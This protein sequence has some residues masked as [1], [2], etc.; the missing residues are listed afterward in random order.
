ML[1]SE[2]HQTRQ[3]NENLNKNPRLLK[4]RNNPNSKKETKIMQKQSP[5]FVPGTTYS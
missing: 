1:K 2:N 3:S 5:V 4:L